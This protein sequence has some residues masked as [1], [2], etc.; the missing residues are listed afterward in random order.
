MAAT[1]Y[2]FYL[3]ALQSVVWD[4]WLSHNR[5]KFDK[6]LQPSHSCHCSS[7][8]SQLKVH[9]LTNSSLEIIQ[10]WL[11]SN[12][13]AFLAKYFIRSLPFCSYLVANIV[14]AFPI[15][16]EIIVYS[17]VTATGSFLWCY[18]QNQS[19]TNNR[20]KIDCNFLRTYVN[21]LL[22]KY[23]IFVISSGN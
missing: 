16:N 19:T 9:T 13:Y 21:L 7:A 15:K 4:F 22:T 14:D 8:V 11:Y 3:A 20:Q 17:T 23:A 10:A 2:L 12:M 6:L 1:S 18:K 5:H